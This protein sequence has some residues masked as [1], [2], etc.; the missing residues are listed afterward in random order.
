[1][2]AD[3]ESYAWIGVVKALQT[4]DS[5]LAG[6]STHAKWYIFAE[7]RLF[8]KRELKHKIDSEDAHDP[9]LDLTAFSGFYRFGDDEAKLI[10]KRAK[11]ILSARQ[12]E[13]LVRRFGLTKS[14]VRETLGKIG[15]SIRVTRERVRQI[16]DGAIKKL[17]LDKV[18]KEE[19]SFMNEKEKEKKRDNG[20][21]LE[22]GAKRR[23]TNVEN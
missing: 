23:K 5:K 14:G 9:D 13:V 17:S 3:A 8:V 11:T 4:Y 10:R 19:Y 15:A 7:L 1:L 16:A 6:F 2:R 22:S 12:Y 20:I 18:L 21:S